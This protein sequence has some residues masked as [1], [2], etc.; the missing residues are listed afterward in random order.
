MNNFVSPGEVLTLTAP[1]GGVTK[2]LGYR[3]GSLVVLATVTADAGDLFAGLVEGVATVLKATGSAWTEGEKL[4]W[5][6]SAKKFTDSAGG[7]TLVG[8]AAAAAGS[9]D[10]TG[11]VRL[12][13]VAR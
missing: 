8:V 11:K 2:G 9:G 1:I 10:T 4:Y 12:D 5:D 6:N 7:N 13:G 3:I